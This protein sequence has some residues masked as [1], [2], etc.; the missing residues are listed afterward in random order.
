MRLRPGRPFRRPNPF[1]GNP[2]LHGPTRALAGETMRRLD[3]A[4]RLSA[5][6]QVARAAA[7]PVEPSP[8][9]DEDASS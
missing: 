8:S 4:Q 3:E 5:E 9:D 2:R 1:G 7:S 6:G